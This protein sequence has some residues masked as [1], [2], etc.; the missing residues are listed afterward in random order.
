MELLSTAKYYAKMAL[1]AKWAMGLP[2]RGVVD[3]FRIYRDF[4][5]LRKQ[6]GLQPQE[7]EDFDF[8]KLDK[9]FRNQFLGVNEQRYYLDLLNPL[10]YYIISRNKFLAHQVMDSAGIR[11]ARLFCFYQPEGDAHIEGSLTARRLEDVLR[12]LK[13]QEVRQCVVKT[14]ES[15]HGDNVWVIADVEY[16]DKDAV[17]IRFDGEK[18]LLSN[19]LGTEQLLFES[20]VRQTSQFSE[21]NATSVNTVRFM[22]TLFP[23]GSARVVAAFI[24]IGRAG[25]CVDNAGDGGNVDVCINVENGITQFAT[26][27]DG[28]HRMK[29][30]EVHPDTNSQLVGVAINHWDEIKNDVIRFQQAFPYCK[31]AG[32]D[33]AITDEGPVVIEVNDFWDRIG[34]LFI[35]HG[36]REEMRDC[37]LA[38]RAMGRK[39]TIGRGENELPRSFLEKI[40]KR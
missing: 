29:E 18:M 17:L 5:H 28:L 31:A 2:G 12:L 11:Q 34:Q 10:K 23:D 37:F 40:V 30:I 39:Y 3:R 19:L 7:Y 6:K 4:L 20:I 35:R 26:K 15:S 33:I 21:F 32:W 27:Y 36:W 13:K 25:K 38:W 8:D 9:D 1:A 24:K 22:T 16:K 14:T